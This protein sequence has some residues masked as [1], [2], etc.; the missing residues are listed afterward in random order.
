MEN[1]DL[2]QAKNIVV[3]CIKTPIE[4]KE[5]IEKCVKRLRL[6]ENVVRDKRPDGILNKSKCI[7]GNAVS[8]LIRSGVI[9]QEDGLLGYKDRDKSQKERVETVKRDTTIEKIMFGVIEEKALSKK[10]LLSEVV[11]R[12]DASV[13]GENPSVLKADAGRLLSV[14]EKSGKVVKDEN[15]RYSVYRKPQESIKDR[16]ARLF[17]DLGDEELVDKTVLML[18]TWYAKVDGYTGIDSK[19]VDGSDDGGIDGIIKGRNRMG[20]AEKVIVQVKKI[21][22]EGRYVPLCEVREFYGVF[23]ATPDATQA[24]FVTNRKYHKGSKDFVNRLRHFVLIDGEKWLQL[25]EECGFE[26]KEEISR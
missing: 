24:V 7:F 14:A 6:P 17:K 25:A 8:A 2:A 13:P 12:Y 3:E 19:N 10:E 18:E 23:A 5:L 11:S 26:L 20:S 1:L 22:K 15:G 16:N 9:V 4:R 21:N